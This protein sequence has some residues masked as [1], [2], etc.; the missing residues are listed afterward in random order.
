MG[1]N[2]IEKA[3]KQTYK[4]L[5]SLLGYKESIH[6]KV[7]EHYLH[8]HVPDCSISKEVTI[9]Y[10]TSDGFVYAYGRMDLV[11]ETLEE[12]IILELKAN[13]NF[14]AKQLECIAQ[15]SRYMV[16]AQ[17][18]KKVRGMLIVFGNHEPIVRYA[19]LSTEKTVCMSPVYSK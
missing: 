19:T 13:I 7:L 9:T 3:I 15:L 5:P 11:L 6:Q 10:K 8:K 12:Y 2:G 14:R 1:S 17:S 16:H 18:E 4:E